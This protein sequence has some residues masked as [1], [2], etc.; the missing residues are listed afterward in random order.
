MNLGLFLWCNFLSQVV[1]GGSWVGAHIWATLVGA[2]R[3]MGFSSGF[4]RCFDKICPGNLLPALPG[5]DWAS[6]LARWCFKFP[7]WD[8]PLVSLP[9]S[10]T[11]K[12]AAK[13]QVEV[14]K[15][16]CVRRQECWSTKLFDHSDCR[17]VLCN[18]EWEE[19]FPLVCSPLQREGLASFT[20]SRPQNADLVLLKRIKIIISGWSGKNKAEQK[21]FSPI[22]TWHLFLL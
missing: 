20:R 17:S 16:H 14:C 15:G 6:S 10:C 22:V 12:G 18:Q 8:L 1:T 3:Q 4:K 5:R 7:H 13:E 11:W 21:F 2:V 9:A 19:S